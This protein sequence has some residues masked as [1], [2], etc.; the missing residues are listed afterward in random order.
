MQF[1]CNLDGIFGRFFLFVLAILKFWNISI[2]F[3]NSLLFILQLSYFMK[4]LIPFFFL[5]FFLI[6]FYFYFVF[7][8]VDIWTVCYIVVVFLAAIAADIFVYFV[9]E[10]FVFK[11]AEFLMVQRVFFNN[12]YKIASRAI[13]NVSR[14]YTFAVCFSYIWSKKRVVTE[15]FSI[16][17][18]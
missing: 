4:P 11:K 7:F 10:N 16:L 5:F 2:F 14:I 13:S 8:V 6:C 1:G 15:Y 3:C 12:V 9:K 18:E 17:K